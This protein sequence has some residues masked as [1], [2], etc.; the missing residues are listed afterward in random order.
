MFGAQCRSSFCAGLASASSDPL[1]CLVEMERGGRMCFRVLDGLSTYSVV[2]GRRG[3]GILEG[4][5]L[6]MV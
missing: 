5:V 1:K 6:A 4:D 2:S 3:H